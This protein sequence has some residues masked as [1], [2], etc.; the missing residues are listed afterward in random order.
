MHFQLKT[1]KREGHLDF[2]QTATLPRIAELVIDVV[3]TSD[4]F[5]IGTVTYAEPVVLVEGVITMTV[6][7][8]CSRCLTEFERGLK[9]QL[10]AAFTTEMS[11]VDDDVP[12]IE[13]DVIDI[14]PKV[15][16]AIF[17]DL[18][19]RPICQS[20]CQGLCPQCGINRNEETCTCDTRAIDPRLAA[21]KD[22]LSDDS[23]E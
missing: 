20:N 23:S 8:I 19:D 10:S 16:E 18:D 1:I 3:N 2:E 4:V 13:G 12:L 7:Y 9:T 5:V 21:L 6:T 15:E 22:L 17:L 11:Q 14:T